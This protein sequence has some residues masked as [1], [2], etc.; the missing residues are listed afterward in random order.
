MASVIDYDGGLKRIEFCLT[1]NGQR[2]SLRLGRVNAKTAKFW[3]DKVEAI[4]GDLLADKPHDS[5]VSKWL[6]RMDESMLKRMRAVGLADGVG[7]SQ[8]T[9]GEFLDRYTTNMTGKPGTRI[10]Y[11]HTI[12]NLREY[13][14]PQRAVRD[15]SNQDAD[16]WR[17]WMVEHEKLSP[18]TV[19]RRVVAAR[20][21]W[22]AAI[23][24]NLAGSNPFAGVK[25]GTQ[26]N[27]SRK[28]FIDRDTI[29]KLLDVA[30]DPEWRAIIALARFGG[31]RIP[32]EIFALRWQDIDW[33]VGKMIVHSCK[34]EHH[35][36]KAMRVV[37]LFEELRPH[38]LACFE[39]AEVGAEYVVSKHRLGGMNLRTQLERFITRAKLTAWPRLWQNMR[40][41]RE[42]ELMRQYDLTT[43]CRWIGNSPAIAA[44]HYAMSVDLNADFQRASGIGQAQQKAQQ[45]AQQ[46]G[47]CSDGQ[48]MTSP[49]PESEKTPQN[50]GFVDACPALATAGETGAWAIQDSN[51]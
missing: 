9:L 48:R 40:A 20:T 39:A 25:G 23:R 27:E 7:L 51:L 30:S 50:A 38:L 46:S 13:F 34:T 43:V 12:A 2:K 3:Q 22:K 24:W 45:K 35:A 6:G 4:I 8:T 5:E 1:P 42:S 44:K 28:V 10:F 17:A 16:G 49:S 31:L 14:T 37:P 47:D 18:A 41:S 36:G 32:S 26:E 33:H 19:A 21:V 15:I 11:G 29:A